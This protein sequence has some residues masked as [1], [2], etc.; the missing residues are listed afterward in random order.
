[1]SVSTEA[2]ARRGVT[3]RTAGA[4]YLAFIVASFLADQIGRIGLSNED[5]LADVIA[6]S[7]ARFRAGLAIALVSL[8]FF[9]LAAWALAEL[10]RPF[11]RGLALLLLVLNAVGAAI[12][13]ASLVVLS[14]GLAAD[15]GD[16]VAVAIEVHG[17]GVVAAQV[18]FSAWLFPLGMLLLRSGIVPRVLAWLVLLDGV[19]IAW[20]FVQAMLLP[21][22]PE[23]SYPAWAISFAAEAGLALWLL[24]R[25]ARTGAT[26]ASDASGS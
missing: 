8:L 19:A 18:F 12:H 5:A 15:A 10:L 3:A 6:T 2:A 21:D 9:V 4:F 24:V 25:G 23:L 7:E 1:M 20:W 16:A 17:T 13:A 14:V 22:S 11:G 26:E